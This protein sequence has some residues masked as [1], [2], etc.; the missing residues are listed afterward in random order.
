MPQLTCTPNLERKFHFYYQLTTITHSHRLWRLSF[1]Y[2]KQ[3][4]PRDETNISANKFQTDNVQKILHHL[5]I[6]SL[7]PRTLVRH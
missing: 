7:K 2:P 3:A 6:D 1:S 5:T 4:I